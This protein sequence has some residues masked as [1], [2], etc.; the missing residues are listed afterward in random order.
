MVALAL[1]STLVK[2]CL[3]GTS[4]RW[5]SGLRSWVARTRTSSTVPSAPSVAM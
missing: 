1:V 4:T 5:P 2:S 3:F